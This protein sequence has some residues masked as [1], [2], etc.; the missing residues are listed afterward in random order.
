MSE[1]VDKIYTPATIE[2]IRA[3]A[4]ELGMTLHQAK[5]KINNA[6]Y[7]EAKKAMK[8]DVADQTAAILLDLQIHGDK[9]TI[10][11]IA[12][13]TRLIRELSKAV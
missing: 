13:M 10:E 7:F 3:T 9:N 8:E 6:R 1:A 4:A 5:T 12:T 11:H 2:E